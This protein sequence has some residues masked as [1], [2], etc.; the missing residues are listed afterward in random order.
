MP[1]QDLLKR[2]I[3]EGVLA[4]PATPFGSGGAVDLDTYAARLRELAAYRPAAMVVAGGA[5]ELFALSVAEHGAIVKR[6]AETVSDIPIIAGVGFG[7]AIACEM[8]RASE[9][10][11]AA[12]VLL[13]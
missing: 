10:A 8:A 4:F 5:G 12:A 9:Y 2:R 13:F 7:V 11:G 1:S 6:S 3:A